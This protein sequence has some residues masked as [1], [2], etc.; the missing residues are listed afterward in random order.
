MKRHVKEDRF[1]LKLLGQKI[2]QEKEVK[3]LGL[4]IDHNLNFNS[5][6]DDIR[7]K[8]RARLDIIRI[9]SKKN[10]SLDIATLGSIYKTLI[11]SVID[12]S[13]PCLNLLSESN[14]KKLQAFQNSAVRTI[15]K[16]KYDTSSV[17]LHHEALTRL[18]LETVANRLDGL[19]E[20]YVR[21]GLSNSV[22]LV[23]RLVEEY[24]RGFNSRNVS[25]STPLCNCYLAFNQTTLQ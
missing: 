6:V 8:C 17:N 16:L 25:Y 11:G 1:E 20:R 13:F 15:L 23:V 3:F 2:P 4:K 5:A 12:Y 19:T 10:S 21:N 14:L 7:E 22:Q 24:Q 18:G 9:L